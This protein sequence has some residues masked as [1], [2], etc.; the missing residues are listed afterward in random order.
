MLQ[1]V[2]L[3]PGQI[4][5]VPNRLVFLIVLW[6]PG[7][8]KPL[9]EESLRIIEEFINNVGA[10]RWPETPENTKSSSSQSGP[11]CMAKH[12]LGGLGLRADLG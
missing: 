5:S 1:V 8:P 10:M 2:F 9:R 7:A 4:K 6:I 3:M 11:R 12:R